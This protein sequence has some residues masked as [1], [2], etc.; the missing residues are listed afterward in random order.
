MLNINIEDEKLGLWYLKHKKKSKRAKAKAKRKRKKD[1]KIESR[2]P[3][4]EKRESDRAEKKTRKDA[5]IRR[6]S[7]KGPR[8]S[9]TQVASERK[10]SRPA[11]TKVS[12]PTRQ[13][14]A[15]GSS[16]VAAETKAQFSAFKAREAAKESAKA[17]K[18]FDARIEAQKSA[19]AEAKKTTRSLALFDTNVAKQRADIAKRKGSFRPTTRVTASFEDDAGP[20]LGGIATRIGPRPGSK[21]ASIRGKAGLALMSPAA[22]TSALDTAKKVGR[23][24]FRPQ[25]EGRGRQ[26][27]G[28][29][30]PRPLGGSIAGTVVEEE[31][32]ISVRQGKFLAKATESQRERAANLAS[33]LRVSGR[34]AEELRQ[35]RLR[36]GKTL[37]IATE[38]SSL[39]PDREV[40][41]PVPGTAKRALIAAEGLSLIL[42]GGVVTAPVKIGAR[43]VARPVIGFVAPKVARAVAPVISRG[44][45]LVTKGLARERVITVGLRSGKGAFQSAAQRARELGS[46]T[47]RVTSPAVTRTAAVASRT[48]AAAGRAGTAAAKPFRAA[49]EGAFRAISTVPRGVRTAGQTVRGLARATDEGA[50]LARASTRIGTKSSRQIA[51]R[52]Q[53][54]TRV[55]REGGS[56]ISVP[57]RNPFAAFGRGVSG[58]TRAAAR[59]TGTQTRRVVTPI[60]RTIGGR[61]VK[62][63]TR[64]IKPAARATGRGTARVTRTVVKPTGKVVKPV[65]R[66][67]GRLLRSPAGLVVGG[68]GAVV[69]GGLILQTLKGAGPAPSQQA[70]AAP[71]PAASPD[72]RRSQRQ[73]RQAPAQAAQPARATVISPARTTKVTPTISPDRIVIDEAATQAPSR[74]PIVASPGK[75]AQTIEVP[76]INPDGSPVIDPTTGE[77]VTTVVDIVDAPLI[78]DEPDLSPFAAVAPLVA[79]AAGLATGLLSRGRGGTSSS[80]SFFGG[81][82]SF[83]GPTIFRTAEGQTGIRIVKD[84]KGTIT[85]EVERIPVKRFTIL[86]RPLVRR[87][88]RILGTSVQ[89]KAIQSAGQLLASPPSVGSTTVIAG[90]A[91]QGRPN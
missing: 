35:T 30:V 69:G 62:P 56:I 50:D 14:A 60:T 63:T 27:L 34:S 1:K 25:D 91:L 23:A 13:R 85:L 53:L 3:K 89:S 84:G 90:R 36:I 20:D 74:A 81:S 47:I 83:I 72:T 75:A 9:S 28:T 86:G 21:Q 52:A 26:S 54:E 39:R 76:T 73:Q 42:P 48:T 6:L 7:G 4:S 37:G 31:T 80:Q 17:L 11:A 66:G 41:I 38:F 70:P 45:G 59:A 44:T 10:V 40:L 29:F 51:Q 8:K 5:A 33:T 58:A 68:V 77:V 87:P 78:K 22:A 55:S 19:I 61:I 67:T 82:S 64:V 88:T 32:G 46:S 49:G 79:G 2:R 12:A 15:S 24:I 16:A 65:A 43:L 18:A 57:K 71:A